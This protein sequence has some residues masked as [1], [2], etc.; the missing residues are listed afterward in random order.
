MW[1]TARG[2]WGPAEVKV[3]LDYTVS[4]QSLYACI[5]VG[6]SVQLQLDLVR[7]VSSWYHNLPR[8]IVTILAFYN[9]TSW[10][11]NGRSKTAIPT[12]NIAAELIILGLACPSH[13]TQQSLT[14]IHVLQSYMCLQPTRCISINCICV[15]I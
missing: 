8:K 7:S 13:N 9:A 5:Y 10:D 1:F 6:S 12:H 2:T 14:A 3:G 4:I 11:D 15:T